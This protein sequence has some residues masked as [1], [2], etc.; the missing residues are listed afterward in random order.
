M[1]FVDIT[2]SKVR[3]LD[4][5]KDPIKRS[6]SMESDLA[7]LIFEGMSDKMKISQLEADLGSALIELME[8]KMGGI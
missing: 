2:D 6:E 1:Q 5:R 4:E 3:H 7:V 8:M